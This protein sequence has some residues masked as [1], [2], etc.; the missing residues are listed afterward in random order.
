VIASAGGA[1]ARSLVEGGDSKLLVEGCGPLIVNSG[2]AGYYRT[3]YTPALLDRLTKSY[4]TLK[5]IDQI[6]LLADNW[7]LG[8][9][10]YQSSA[11]AL[12]MVAALPAQA[13]SQLYG[14]VA[15]IL[16]QL[17][18]L[19][20]GD[21]AHQAMVARLA[22]AKLGP[23]LD[24]IGW[25]ARAGEASNDAV[26]RAELIATL[27]ALGDRDVVARA[28]RLYE[29]KDPLATGGSLRST[30]LG[31]VSRNVD[32]AGW[33]RLRVAAQAEKNPLVKASLYRQLGTARDPALAQRAL[34]LALTDEPGATT[35]SAIIS[36]VAQVHPDLAFDFALRNRDKV[37]TLVD[38]S[39][40]SRFI[41]GLAATSGEAATA[42]KL[43]QYAE[44]Q[45]TPESRRPAD[46]SIAAIGDRLR[47]RQTRL[48]DISRWLEAH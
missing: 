25:T 32:P 8:L 42:E 9:A 28:R 22:S 5:P 34:E 47:I 26:L 19:Y 48:P 17:F 35:G 4:A 27:G 37:Q 39:S 38:E 13:N 6:G 44:R 3:L 10:G 24:R 29:G 33:E 30:I 2:Q 40:R 21:G 1:K 43:R 15:K 12:D 31:V 36:T 41:P 23:A 46:I 7:S 45:M 20:D 16:D 18:D 11:L 14:R